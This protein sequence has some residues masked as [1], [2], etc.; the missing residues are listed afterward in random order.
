MKAVSGESKKSRSSSQ[1][2][3][4][5]AIE[6]QQRDNIVD[7]QSDVSNSQVIKRRLSA[8]IKAENDRCVLLVKKWEAK[9]AKIEEKKNKIREAKEENLKE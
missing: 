5:K 8:E 2:F 9:Q 6:D 1:N 4:L 7:N 3:E